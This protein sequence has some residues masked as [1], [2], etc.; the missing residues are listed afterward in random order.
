MPLDLGGR[1]TR[2]FMVGGAGDVAVTL[3]KRDAITLVELV[4]G[5]GSIRFGSRKVRAPV[6][7][8]GIKAVGLARKPIATY[9]GLAAPLN[10][11]VGPPESAL[12]AGSVPMISVNHPANA[13][14]R[15]I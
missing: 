13:I 8:P 12:W 3:K 2:G 7:R 10:D 11:R 14:C 9:V 15:D 5:S 6:R 1:V 4:A